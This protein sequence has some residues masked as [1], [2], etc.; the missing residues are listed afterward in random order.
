MEPTGV[1]ANRRRTLL[2]YIIP[3]R[4]AALVA[5]LDL[6]QTA[7]DAPTALVTNDFGCQF[8][9]PVDKS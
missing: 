7:H 5:P 8:G 6:P 3:A 2:A 1:Q 4:R 9:V